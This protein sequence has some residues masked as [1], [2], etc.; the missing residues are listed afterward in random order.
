MSVDL[1][2]FSLSEQKMSEQEETEENNAENVKEKVILSRPPLPPPLPPT[3]IFIEKLFTTYWGLSLV[4]LLVSLATILFI[5]GDECRQCFNQLE[6]PT[7]KPKTFWAYGKNIDANGYLKE[8]YAVLDQLGFKQERDNKAKGSNWDLL[9]AHD[10]PFRALRADLTHL[11]PHQKINHF[12]GSGY[13]TNKV[14]LATSGVPFVPPAFKL[15]DQKAALL[16]YAADRSNLTFVQKNNDHRNIKVK[17]LDQMDL[18]KSGTFVQEFIDKPLLIDGHKFDIGIYTIITSIDPLRVYIY[19]GEALLRF[20]PKKYHPFD[21]EDLNKYVVGD[22]YLPVWRVPVLSEYYN[23]LGFGM[24]HSLDAYLRS[25]GEEPQRIWNEIEEAVRSVVLARE[26]LIVDILKRYK[27]KSNF[28]EMMRFDFVVDE[29][30]HVHLLEANMSPNLSSA[31]YPPNRLLY[32]QVLYNVFGLVGVGERIRK[33]TDQSMVVSDKHLVTYPEKCASDLCKSGCASSDCQLCKSCLSVE[34]RQYLIAAFKEHLNR[35]DCK[36]VFP[37]IESQ[38]EAANTLK[39]GYS[40]ENQL[41]YKW[42]KGKC[43]LDK[44]WCS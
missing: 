18:S 43:L 10:Y 1:G 41:H 19:N 6:N 38:E 17:R 42:F 14:D 33:R 20:C 24:R 15:P 11:K 30:L 29:N 34:T 21:P 31:H 2:Y 12:P 9:W 26:P 22:D 40:V 16:A 27:S 28:F 25:K 36:R 5:L 23:E 3:S 4:F 37:P 35:G 44:T 39:E 8:V 32:H 7:N 13:I